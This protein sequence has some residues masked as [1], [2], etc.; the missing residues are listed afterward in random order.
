VKS[1]AWW[2]RLLAAVPFPLLYLAAHFLAWLALRVFPHRQHVI[3]ENLARAFPD[4]DE[5]GRFVV[6]RDFYRRF[7]EVFVEIVK[8]A[9]MSPD[10]IRR[11]VGIVG[12]EPVRRL[13]DGGSAVILVG[14]HQC[15]WEWMVHALALQLGYRSDVAYKPLRD[16]WAEREMFIIRSR[17]GSRLIPTQDLLRD[18]IKQR[19]TVRAIALLADQ[20]PT[21]SERMH[22]TRFLNRD[23]AFY[24]GPEEIARATRFPV[25]FLGMRRIRRGFYE[26]TFT[27]LA[28][29]PAT[30]PPGALTEAYARTVEQQIRSSPPDWPWSHKR[31]RIKKGIYSKVG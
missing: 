21:R 28:E 22:W 11:R 8:A 17:F 3:Q 30:L 1:S 27:P 15:N 25:Y 23:S 26:M 16:P 13:L 5:T 7:A 24:M 18:I 10:E 4:L 12:M 14:A 29:T 6:M 31:W 2:V 19:N 9:S 20:E